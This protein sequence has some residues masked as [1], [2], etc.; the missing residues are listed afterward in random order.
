MSTVSNW[1]LTWHYDTLEMRDRCVTRLRALLEE[2]YLEGAFVGDERGSEGSSPH[3]QGFMRTSSRRRLTALKKTLCGDY[4]VMAAGCKLEIDDGVSIKMPHVDHRRGSVEQNKRY[5]SKEGNVLLSQGTFGMTQGSRTD[6]AALV[7]A[8]RSRRVRSYAEI[9]ENFPALSRNIAWCHRLL[10]LYFPPQTLEELTSLMRWQIRLIRHLCAPANDREV[11]FVVDHEGRG[12]KSTIT[13]RI[14]TLSGKS[15]LVL[16]PGPVRDMVRALSDR[17][18]VE[19][20]V[21]DTPRSSTEFL[22]YQFLEMAK[23]GRATNFKYEVAPFYL[24]NHPVH[25]VVMMNELPDATKL[26]EDR[27]VVW[28]LGM[29]DKELVPIPREAPFVPSSGKE[30]NGDEAG[31]GPSYSSSVS[32]LNSSSSSHSSSPSSSYSFGSRERVLPRYYGSRYGGK[33][34]QKLVECG[35]IPRE[36]TFA[37]LPHHIRVLYPTEYSSESLVGWPPR[38]ERFSVGSVVHCMAS[39]R[40]VLQPESTVFWLDP[41]ND[42]WFSYSGPLFEGKAVG[43]TSGRRVNFGRYSPVLMELRFQHMDWTYHSGYADTDRGRRL[44]ASIPDGTDPPSRAVVQS[45]SKSQS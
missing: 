23:N 44:A 36:V 19:I 2:D 15:V 40:T 33:T 16:D 7:E 42:R 14:A 5:C 21:I 35:R 22:Q 24:V 30:F 20:V 11:L 37:T 34:L 43:K 6:S 25:V 27:Y 41:E 17:R 1:V 8:V 4:A 12:G 13:D 10:D 26:S 39:G 18:E 38:P 29:S 32:S 28:E 3:L 9:V 45:R 31:D